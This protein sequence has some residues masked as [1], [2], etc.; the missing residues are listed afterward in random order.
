MP[1]STS[2]STGIRDPLRALLGACADYELFLHPSLLRGHSLIVT[3]LH[4]DSRAACRWMERPGEWQ[5]SLLAT[6][7]RRTEQSARQEESTSFGRTAALRRGIL[8]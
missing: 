5:S 7:A 1:V 6:Q 4:F 8:F 2:V 3:L